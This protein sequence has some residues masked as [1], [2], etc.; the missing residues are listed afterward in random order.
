[1]MLEIKVLEKVL[2]TALKTGGDFA[3]IF[4]EKNYRNSISMLN[5]KVEDVNSGIRRGIGLRIYHG[6]ESVYA[7]TN[8]LSEENLIKQRSSY[9]PLLMINKSLNMSNFR[10]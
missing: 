6:L 9:L 7:Y 4:E 8:D 10:K 3:E 1:M 2:E 5:G